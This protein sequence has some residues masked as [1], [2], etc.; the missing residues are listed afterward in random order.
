MTGTFNGSRDDTIKVSLTKESRADGCLDRKWS[1]AE[2]SGRLKQQNEE[3]RKENSVGVEVLVVFSYKSWWWFISKAYMF[4]ENHENEY[5]LKK[6]L[7]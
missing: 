2:R 3:R 1:S 6:Q 4:N 7:R 5:Q